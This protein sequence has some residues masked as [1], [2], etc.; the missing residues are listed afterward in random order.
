MNNCD[1]G[2]V[3]AKK[4]IVNPVVSCAKTILTMFDVCLT[5]FVCRAVRAF[6]CMQAFGASSLNFFVSIQAQASTSTWFK[7]RLFTSPTLFHQCSKCV[8]NLLV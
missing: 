6:I 7:A 1:T 5:W 8:N 2:C 3:L 4:E